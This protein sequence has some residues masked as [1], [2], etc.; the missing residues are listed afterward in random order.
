MTAEP[1]PAQDPYQTY[2]SAKAVV[3]PT[4]TSDACLVYIYPTG[5]HMGERYVLKQSDAVIGRTDD[6]QIRNTDAS[7]SRTHA[8]VECRDDGYYAVDLASTNGTFVNNVP[9]KEVRLDDGDYLRIGNCIYRFLAGGNLEAEYHEEIYRLTVMD[10][11][12]GA[13]NRRY[14]TEFL[15]RELARAQRYDR[16]LTLALFDIDRF[17]RINDVHGHLAGDMALRELA[18]QLKD[19][20]RKDELL[21]RYG[22]EEFAMVLP[23]TTGEQAV[24]ACERL[25]QVVEAHR[26]E[27]GGEVIPV[28]ISIGV[29]CYNS[30][31]NSPEDLIEAADAK[32]YHAKATGRNKVSF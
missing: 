5:P 20:V 15:D 19:G 1:L 8:R 22:G 30:T 11:L 26:F 28:T 4:R 2:K 25:R 14:L 12:T 24:T 10:G 7:V 6:C 18:R 3:L 27:Y 31:M 17:K 23:E 13:H 16:P 32:L 21:A 29:A 9:H